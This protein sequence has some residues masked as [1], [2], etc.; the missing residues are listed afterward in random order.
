MSVYQKTNRTEIRGD[1]NQR[2]PIPKGMW[3]VHT[4]RFGPP[5]H[6]RQV[7]VVFECGEI[8]SSVTYLKVEQLVLTVRH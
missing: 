5:F 3:A 1:S 8:G 6:L 4:K 2:I 7:V